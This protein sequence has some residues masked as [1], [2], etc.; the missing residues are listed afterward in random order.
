MVRVRRETEII[1]LGAY[2]C[3]YDIR[4]RNYFLLILAGL[5]VLTYVGCGAPDTV[6]RK[7]AAVRLPGA[8]GPGPATIAPSDGRPVI[9]AFGDS[10]SAGFGAEPGKSFPD[11]V[12][13]LIDHAGYGYRIYNAGVSG[14]T[15]SDGVERMP[16]VIAL[17]PAIVILEFGGNDGLR[18]LPVT[19]TKANLAQMIEGLQKSEAKV[20]LAGM[21]L[22]RNYG[23]E[24]ITSFE[25]VYEELAARY[26]VPRIPFLLDGVGGVSR[27]MQRDG[28]HPTAQGNA[29][30]AKT[31]FRYL[32]PMLSK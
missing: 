18:G 19:T 12:Q 14:D 25:K 15:T 8:E 2:V 16:E 31:V 4:V 7:D 26:K 6:A 11:Y 5:Y 28:I 21:T 13:R 29:I 1:H 20:L 24:Y 32:E 17:H 23:A 27:L 30:V 9:A 3:H 22:P 10:L